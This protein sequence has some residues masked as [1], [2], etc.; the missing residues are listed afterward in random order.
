[1]NSLA[2][3]CTWYLHTCSVNF[4]S[5]KSFNWF[6]FQSEVQ[7]YCW[8][9]FSANYTLINQHKLLNFWYSEVSF[10]HSA[11]KYL[12]WDLMIFIRNIYDTAKKSYFMFC[13]LIIR[14]KYLASILNLISWSANLNDKIIK[15]KIIKIY[16]IDLWSHYIDVEY[17]DIKIKT[18]HHSTL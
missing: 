9:V 5:W 10:D 12:W 15:V 11:V 2:D 7:Y 14:I 6:V 17:F 3:D 4:N 8:Q 16:F 13:F 1:M 18:F